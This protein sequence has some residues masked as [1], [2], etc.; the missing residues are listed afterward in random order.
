MNHDEALE[1]AKSLALQAGDIM[2]EHF[3][4]GV[5]TRTKDNQTPVTIAD[6]SI[7]QLVIDE[8][9]KNYPEH[10]VLGEE[11]SNLKDGAEYTWICDPIDGTGAYSFG[12]AANVFSLI[13]T[14]DG[15]P[16]LGVVYDPYLKRL[17]HAIKGQ[18]AFA[19]DQPLHVNDLNLAEGHVGVS[20]QTSV[21]VDSIKLHM[22]IEQID[23]RNLAI[24][25]SVYEA[26]MVA[27]GQFVACTYVGKHAHDVVAAKLFVEEAGGK[28]TD[29]YGNEQRYDRPVKGILASNGVVHEELLAI[30]AKTYLQ[31]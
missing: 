12:L 1:V 7:N 29:L 14:K 24:G 6:E 16:V 4:L 30:I 23:H 27:A 11:Q 25:S 26:M 20:N 22:L 5:T 28:V 19:N 8:L 13:L 21:E 18:G 2:L 10:S 17:F 3:Q 15:Q 9:E 31:S